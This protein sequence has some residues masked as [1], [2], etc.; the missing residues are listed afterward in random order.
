MADVISNLPEAVL[1]HI[2]SFMPTEEVVAT[3]VLSK[4]W[5]ELWRVVPTLDFDHEIYNENKESHSRFVEFVYAVM[6]SR[7]LHQPIQTFSLRCCDHI[8]VNVWI[9]AALQRRV[10]QFNLYL[11][12]SLNLSSAIFSH[13][14][15]VVL[16]LVGSTVPA[17][18][19]VDL[20]SLKILSLCSVVFL[21]PRYLAELLSGCPILEDFKLKKIF[22]NNALPEGEFKRIPMLVRADIHR[23]YI[24]LEIVSNVEFLCLHEFELED[25]DEEMDV[26]N[27]EDTNPSIIDFVPVF[28]NLSHIEVNYMDYSKDWRMVVDMLNYL[29]KLQA[30]VINQVYLDEEHEAE[31][32]DWAYPQSVPESISLQLKTCCLINYTGSK[33]DLQLAKYIMQNATHLRTMKICV[34]MKAN[35]EEKLKMLKKLSSCTRRSATCKL[36]FK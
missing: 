14:T 20:P 13:K 24:P 5:K 3:S 6:L 19:S 33:D 4:R 26:V 17:L 35:P 31:R 15:L 2:L 10:E 16:K 29:P 25:V 27:N 11:P 22:F 12:Q 21:D 30:L 18:S 7:D 9:N 1:C 32:G 28:H 34:Y 8:N 23:G 36:S